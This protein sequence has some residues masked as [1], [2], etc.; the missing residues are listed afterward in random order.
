MDFQFPQYRRLSNGK[1]YYKISSFTTM[2]EIQLL[3]KKYAI[4]ALS[5][6]IWPERLLIQ[7]MLSLQAGVYA[8]IDELEYQSILTHCETELDRIFI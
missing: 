7:D 2:E 4:N 3:P 1:S 5:A 8:I 6:A